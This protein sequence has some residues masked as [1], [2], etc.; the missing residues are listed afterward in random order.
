MKRGKGR[1][2]GGVK[3]ELMELYKT[4]SNM[5]DLWDHSLLG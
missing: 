2:K 4:D 1:K 3:W 5:G